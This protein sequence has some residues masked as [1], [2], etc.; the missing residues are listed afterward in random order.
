MADK[1][2]FAEWAKD[3]SKDSP[4]TMQAPSFETKAITL[5]RDK[6]K[7][8]DEL[9][10]LLAGAPSTVREAAMDSPSD[11]LSDIVASF[12]ISTARVD[13][14]NTTF[15]VE[16]WELE[17]YKK[18]PV[19]LFGHDAWG[20]PIGRDIG[21]HVLDDKTAL[22]GVARFVDPSLDEEGYK[23]AKMVRAGLINGA[24]IR[25]DPIEW[26]YN[27]ERDGA[28]SMWSR[29]VDFKRQ[30]LTEWSV[31]VLPSNLD[32]VID[33]ARMRSAQLTKQEINSMFERSLGGQN[34]LLAPK[35]KLEE[36]ALKTRSSMTFDMGALG[37]FTLQRADAVVD[38]SI[39][40]AEAEKAKAEA[41]AAQVEGGDTKAC[42]T[43]EN[44]RAEMGMCPECGHEGEIAIFIKPAEDG[45]GEGSAEGEPV[46]DEG[47]TED[48]VV[49]SLSDEQLLA[50]LNKRNP[51]LIAS[52]VDEV[53]KRSADDEDDDD[54]LDDEEIA[55]IV[56]ATVEA[57]EAQEAFEKRGKLA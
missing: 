30:R 57:V 4:V 2:T 34:F 48:E 43:D 1:K 36:L 44:A 37:K 49:R 52:I 18:N 53:A 29:P 17:D 25:F 54:E 23:V 41:D 6:G 32:C 31:V 5:S 38:E 28:D 20:C 42:A 10:A 13:S 11:G 24:S 21:V 26:E 33:E 12:T 7:A 9:A 39:A 16:G 3:P 46:A 19:V 8:R 14:Y 45:S 15:A 35:E 56:A 22:K 51:N 50:V 47:V 27:S 55:D 40:K